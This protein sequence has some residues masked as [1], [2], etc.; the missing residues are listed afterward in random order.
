MGKIKIVIF[1]LGTQEFAFSLEDV[2]EVVRLNAPT[3]PFNTT[4]CVD[5]FI[6]L[7]DKIIPVV[8]L[9]S[10][11]G[12][13]FVGTHE[14]EDTHAVIIDTG[15]SVFAAIVQQVTD[16][17]ELDKEAIEPYRSMTRVE[18]KYIKGAVKISNRRILLVQSKE[19]LGWNNPAALGQAI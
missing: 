6:T 2:R 13:N 16:V 5:E 8:D 18:G 4:H 7:R 3:K 10:C 19:L 1:Q 17:M 15:T 12:I 11:F 14:N 9:A